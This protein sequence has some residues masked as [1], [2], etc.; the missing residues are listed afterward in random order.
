LGDLLGWE[1]F[2]ARRRVVA[3]GQVSARVG[4][5]GAALPARLP[6]TAA[7]FGGGRASLRHVDVI[8]RLLGGAAAGRLSP[9]QW[10]GVEEQLAA[11]TDQYTPGELY[12]WGTRLVDALDQDGAEPDDRPPPGSTSCTSPATATAAGSSRA[13]STTPRCSPRSPR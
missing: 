4:L 1:R 2:Q 7:M 8:A 5:D 3:A 13:G 6:A 9:Q 10:A 12:A 11:K